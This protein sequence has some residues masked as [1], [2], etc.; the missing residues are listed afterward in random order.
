LQDRN[1]EDTNNEMKVVDRVENPADR[2]KKCKRTS[3][4]CTTED[5]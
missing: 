2:S 3:T 1:Y 4:Y 5:L